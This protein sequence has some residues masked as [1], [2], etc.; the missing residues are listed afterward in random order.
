MKIVYRHHDIDQKC[1]PCM[2]MVPIHK[3][4]YMESISLGTYKI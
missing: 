2:Q 3:S 4:N 1:G